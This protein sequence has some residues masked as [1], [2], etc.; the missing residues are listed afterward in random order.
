M[1]ILKGNRNQCTICNEYFNSNTPFELHRVGDH[2][3]N[4]RCKTKEEMQ[5]AGMCLNDQGF[6][7]TGKMPD[8]LKGHYE[9]NH[10]EEGSGTV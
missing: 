10:A 7:T 6:W 2:G 8:R 1:R 3:V 9:H 4:R 5:A